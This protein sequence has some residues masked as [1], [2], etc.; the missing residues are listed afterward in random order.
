M[1]GSKGGTYGRHRKE[2]IPAFPTDTTAST[3]EPLHLGSEAGWVGGWMSKEFAM[4]ANRS[5]LE[6]VGDPVFM[7]S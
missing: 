2:I 7:F 5:D 1:M 3:P 4:F 6:T